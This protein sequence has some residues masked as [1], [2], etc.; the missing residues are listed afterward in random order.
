MFAGPDP[1]G[2]PI[3]ATEVVQGPIMQTLEFGPLDAGEYYYQC[4]VHAQMFGTLTAFAPGTDGGT[5][6]TTP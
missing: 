5:T 3:A 4:Q 2:N 6:G 1:E